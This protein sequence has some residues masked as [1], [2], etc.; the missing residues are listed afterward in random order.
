MSFA[1]IAESFT[2][3]LPGP[4]AF[5]LARQYLARYESGLRGG[6]ALH[7]AIARTHRATAIYSLDRV[8]IKAGDLFGLPV[9][10]G[11]DLDR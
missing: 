9:S 5:D 2:V 6:D 1:I 8:L 3:L 10:A 7:L 11:I 4:E